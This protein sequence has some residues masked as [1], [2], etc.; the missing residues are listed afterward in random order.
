MGIRQTIETYGTT[1]IADAMGLPIS[2]VHTWKTSDAIPG[3][4]ILH[5]MR[6]EAFETAV[7]ALKRQTK[8]KKAA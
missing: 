5:D 2:T 4:G 7:K 8:R 6:V 3:R 1:A